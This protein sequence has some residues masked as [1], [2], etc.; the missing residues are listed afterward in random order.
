MR[1]TNGQRKYGR[2]EPEARMAV[3]DGDTDLLLGTIAD[4]SCGGLKLEGTTRL[5]IEAEVSIV[6]ELEGELADLGPLALC[7]CTRWRRVIDEDGNLHQGL[8][9]VQ[10][11]ESEAARRLSDLVFRLSI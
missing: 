7:A 5:E 6:V 3:R 8:E 11:L 4:I 2:V 10:P 1:V 9:F